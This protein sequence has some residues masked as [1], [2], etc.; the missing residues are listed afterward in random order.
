MGHR[1]W[2]ALWQPGAG[3]PCPSC[4]DLCRC[5][6][7]G[8]KQKSFPQLYKQFT[9]RCDSEPAC[10]HERRQWPLQICRAQGT[11][12]P[13]RWN[14]FVVSQAVCGLRLES[15]KVMQTQ[16]WFLERDLYYGL[17][18]VIMSIILLGKLYKCRCGGCRHRAVRSEEGFTT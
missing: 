11:G 12:D 3:F 1:E 14:H 15:V 13:N 7:V 6:P 8:F 5:I 4:A 2:W 18:G 16:A 10:H 17:V 9:A